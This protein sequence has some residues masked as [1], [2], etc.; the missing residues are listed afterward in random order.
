MRAKNQKPYNFEQYLQCSHNLFNKILSRRTNTHTRLLRRRFYHVVLRCYPS[1][2]QMAA[3]NTNPSFISNLPQ[4]LIHFPFTS[5]RATTTNSYNW[6]A[7]IQRDRNFGI[8]SFD[9]DVVQTWYSATQ[10]EGS[11][12]RPFDMFVPIGVRWVPF[13]WLYLFPTTLLPSEAHIPRA[14]FGP[15]LVVH[16]AQ[17]TGLCPITDQVRSEGYDILNIS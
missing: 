10:N 15:V 6:Y 16:Q 7:L 17:Q 11:C 3:S 12:N 4:F 8:L 9:L 14:I 13:I 1:P 5:I 2:L